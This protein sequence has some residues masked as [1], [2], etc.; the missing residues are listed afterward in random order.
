MPLNEVYAIMT[1][2]GE[3]YVRIFELYLKFPMTFEYH[4]GEYSEYKR[5]LCTHH[6]IGNQ[7]NSQSDRE[8][9]HY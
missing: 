1:T 9:N 4:R 3:T 8:T 2:I 6:E 5:T 7:Y